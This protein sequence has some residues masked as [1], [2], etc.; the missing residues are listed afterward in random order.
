MLLLCIILNGLCHNTVD[1][2]CRQDYICDNEKKLYRLSILR[3]NRWSRAKHS[4]ITAM[5]GMPLFNRLLSKKLPSLLKSVKHRTV[6]CR[7]GEK[8]WNKAVKLS[9]TKRKATEREKVRLLL[10]LFRLISRYRKPLIRIEVTT[11]TRSHSITVEL[12]F[13]Y[14]KIITITI[15]ANSSNGTGVCTNWMCESWSFYSVSYSGL[16]KF[17]ENSVP[18]LLGVNKLFEEYSLSLIAPRHCHEFPF[19]IFA[20]VRVTIRCY[21]GREKPFIILG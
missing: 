5:P 6:S 18:R 20:N 8:P 2:N 19:D 1:I 11:S 12:R 16:C 14:V 4:I 13:S 15:S 10:K 21:R 17:Y 9:I 3:P 7:C